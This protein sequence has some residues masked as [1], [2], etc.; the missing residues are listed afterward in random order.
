MTEK[1]IAKKNTG[2]DTL[3]LALRDNIDVK[4]RFA[5][6][7]DKRAPAFM[8]S[9]L[10]VV[11][12]EKSLQNCSVPS[13]LTA[14]AKAAV[15]NLPIEKSLGYAYIVPFGKDATFILGYKGMIQLAMRTR[16]YKS[17]NSDAVY[18]G[19]EVV[20]DRITGN[21][22]IRGA[23]VADEEIGYFA[24]FRM[25]N[26]YEKFVYM[27]VED[28]EKHAKKYSKS[29]G[30]KKSAWTTNFYEMACKTVLRRLLSRWGLFSIDMLDDD[31]DA[32]DLTGNDPRFQTPEGI[33]MPDFD[34][35]V[36][37]EFVG[38]EE[39][40]VSAIIDT[41]LS[42][43][44]YAVAGALKK[45]TSD[46]STPDLAIAW[47]RLYRGWRDLDNS[48]DEAAKKANAGETP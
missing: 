2:Y 21:I 45:A 7:L 11:S 27:T 6:I 40:A 29:Y 23:K 43:N 33:V 39:T 42:D 12:E 18:Q 34:D 44:G 17:I 26:G 13:I 1:T 35:I 14:A 31:A 37:A 48:S 16:M 28:V 5:T 10:S 47:Y 24:F 20:H 19:E 36:D 32:V 3:K 46:I 38:G 30:N 15:L 4:E 8:S 41:G 22:E 25:N 9:L